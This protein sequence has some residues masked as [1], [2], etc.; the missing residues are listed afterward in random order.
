MFPLVELDS[1]LSF[2]SHIYTYDVVNLH[3]AEHLFLIAPEEIRD[4]FMKIFRGFGVVKGH[5]QLL[6]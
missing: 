4:I 2:K 6:D 5:I 1:P 3:L